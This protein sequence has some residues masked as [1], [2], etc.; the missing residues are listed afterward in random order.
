MNS[1]RYS[2][3]PAEALATLKLTIFFVLFSRTSVC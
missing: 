1:Y 3:L 2:S